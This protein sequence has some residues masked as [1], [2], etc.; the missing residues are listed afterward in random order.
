MRRSYGRGVLLRRRLGMTLIEIIVVL[1]ILGLIAGAIAVAVLPQ[2]GEA[3]RDVARQE[4]SSLMT[5]VKTYNV[6]KGK[7]PE[8][9]NLK[10]LEDGQF[11][12]KLKKDPWGN[13][14][15]YLNEGN[16]PV[17]ISYGEDGAQGG[18]GLAADISSRDP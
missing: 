8:S 7:Y 14:F 17:I 2:F 13:D 16:K 5:A 4:I 10:A 9:G 1:A 18:E 15:V 6:R 3:K 11:I 12:E